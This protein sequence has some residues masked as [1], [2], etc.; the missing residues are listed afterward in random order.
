MLA[1]N[2]DSRSCARKERGEITENQGEN[3]GKNTKLRAQDSYACTSNREPTPHARSVPLR[4]QQPTSPPTP[5]QRIT[6]RPRK[7]RPRKQ[8]APSPVPCSGT[9][10]AQKTAKR[11]APGRWCRSRCRA[12]RRARG[13]AGGRRGPLRG[14]PG[15][16]PRST[17]GEREERGGVSRSSAAGCGGGGGGG[18]GFCGRKEG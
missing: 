10:T 7:S 6:K 3:P 11:C 8:P 2:V 1:G 13:R 4:S 16:C 17:W 9:E 15:A 5:P 12:C 18:R 14:T